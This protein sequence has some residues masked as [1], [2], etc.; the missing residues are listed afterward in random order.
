M[1]IGSRIGSLQGIGTV[2]DDS[3]V[4]FPGKLLLERHAV[5]LP[6][7]TRQ[8]VTT[9]STVVTPLAREILRKRGVAV[10]ISNASSMGS[11]NPVI[12][13]E[14]A[15][16]RLCDSPQA[17]SLES[18]LIGRGGEGWIGFDAAAEAAA[19]WIETQ[20]AGHLAV[21]AQSA[22]HA[23]WW[24]IRQGVRAA[25]VQASA[26]VERIVSEFAPRCL[27]IEPARLPIHES[28]QIYRAWRALGVQP[29]KS[30]ATDSP[31]FVKEAR[32]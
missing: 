4:A 13:G 5:S 19:G 10:R 6:E 16:V 14:W 3:I 25:Q 8:I 15:V 28:R 7:S 26:D 31:Y 1:R 11:P 27:V 9:P 24:L 17:Q 2:K 22:A 30:I 20:P 18:M 23:L 12:A 21:L 29:S 32:S